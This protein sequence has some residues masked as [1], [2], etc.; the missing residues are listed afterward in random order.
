MPT[1]PGRLWLIPNLI[2]P[3]APEAAL[4][5]ATLERV[6]SL[7]H[8][9]VEG[10]RSAWRF[11]SSILDRPALDLVQLTVLDEH[12][13]PDR[14]EE[15][16]SPALAG[17]D[18][19]LLSEAGMPC[20]A[21]PGAPLV[22]LAHERGIRIV[23][24]VGPSSIFLALAASGLNGQRFSFLGYLPS[25]RD[26]RRTALRAINKGICQ[27]GGTR[28]FI[29]A[30]YRNDHLLSDCLSYLSPATRLCLATN[31]G[32]GEES[33]RQASVSTL[34]SAVPTIGKVPTI[35]LAGQV[36][37]TVLDR[38]RPLSNSHDKATQEGRR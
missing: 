23:P 31:I 9:V 21:D 33:I 25:D 8:F 14:I 27:D 6:K 19:G 1:Q 26:G 10:E 22:A 7:R 17:N 30:P 13:P 3:G 28:I 11:L 15:L 16:L 38:P 2:A 12:T 20:I 36:P 24:L 32:S 34:R 4:P 29:E 35:F 18:L 37:Q 5:A